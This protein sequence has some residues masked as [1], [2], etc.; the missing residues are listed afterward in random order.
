MLVERML[1]R[2]EAIV[3]R[4]LEAVPSLRALG[5]R[6]R[7][8]C[9]MDTNHHLEHL[10]QA[11][12]M[13][14]PALFAAYAR[15]VLAVLTSR[16]IKTGALR[17]NFQILEEEL[18]AALDAGERASVRLSV[19]AALDALEEKPVEPGAPPAEVTPYVEAVLKRANAEAVLVLLGWQRERGAAE[20]LRLLGQAQARIGEL[21]MHNQISVADEHRATAA[22]AQG[23]SALAPFIA[24]APGERPKGK[25][26]VACAPG[27][28]HGTGPRIAADLLELEGFEV[29]YLG[30]NTPAEE[31]AR[32]AAELRPVVIGLGIA[33]L[34]ALDGARE[35]IVAVRAAWPAAKVWCG[36]FAA[37]TAGAASLGADWV[38]PAPLCPTP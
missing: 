31:L 20:A 26:L 34:Q 11:V 37:R 18:A 10:H 2:K 1:S 33:P 5:E 28:W 13:K 4:M 16:G 9:A 29:E 8:F 24:G 30:A 32:A 14:E 25:A 3:G 22:A 36:G 12:A 35:A 6:G 38:S 27:D 21:W 7:R 23:L 15:W 19:Q 17:T